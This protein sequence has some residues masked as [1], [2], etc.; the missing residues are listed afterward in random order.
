MVVVVLVASLEL[1]EVVRL[2]DPRQNGKEVVV[3]VLR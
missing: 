2:H 3:I 1:W